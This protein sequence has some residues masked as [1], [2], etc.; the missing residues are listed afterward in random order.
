M[1][2][3][4]P[5]RG[6][7]SRSA[8]ELIATLSAGGIAL[9]R[10]QQQALGRLCRAAAAY[11]RLQ[12]ERCNGPHWASLPRYTPKPGDWE[13]WEA[14]LAA[15]ERRSGKTMM[16]AAGD[17]PFPALLDHA[18]ESGAPVMLRLTDE[19]KHL[20]D[21]LDGEGLCVPGS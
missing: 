12:E 9:D 17:L 5:N 15:R 16:E 10:E 20:H 14:G 19:H 21:S 7:L 4:H 8:L 3:N 18:C 6:K 11:K 13:A 2:R 1:N